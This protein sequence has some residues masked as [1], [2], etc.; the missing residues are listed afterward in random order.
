M[1]STRRCTVI[2]IVYL[3]H[4]DGTAMM[5]HKDSQIYRIEDLRTT[6]I[7]INHAIAIRIKTFRIDIKA[8]EVFWSD[9][10]RQRFF[11]KP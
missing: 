2:K 5:V 6:V 3:G 11:R 8:A 7:A 4:R 1:P 9:E 10:S